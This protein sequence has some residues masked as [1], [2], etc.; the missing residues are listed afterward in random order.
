[1]RPP[2]YN[3]HDI[4]QDFIH[5]CTPLNNGVTLKTIADKYGIP[6]QTVR[7]KAA[8]DKWHSKRY[9][10][11]QYENTDHGRSFINKLNKEIERLQ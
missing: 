3:W 5:D 2:L 9:A 10:L 7:R 4:E 1:M 6:Y 8:A 11:W